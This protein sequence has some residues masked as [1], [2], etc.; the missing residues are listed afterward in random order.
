MK[1]V[2]SLLFLEACTTPGTRQTVHL[3]GGDKY[4]LTSLSFSVRLD[5]VSILSA[6]LSF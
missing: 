3:H 5:Y 1:V 2:L 6:A 4:S